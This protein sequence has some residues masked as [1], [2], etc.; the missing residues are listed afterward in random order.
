MF[1]FLVFAFD[2]NGRL[3][4]VPHPEECSSFYLCDHNLASLFTCQAGLAFD[5]NLLVC[6]YDH[7]VDCEGRQNTMSTTE[8]QGTYNFF[9][10]R[11]NTEY[12]ARLAEYR[13]LK[14]TTKIHFFGHFFINFE[15]IFATF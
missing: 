5:E 2:C 15:P 8:K 12:S 11:P 1:K 10:G 3:G 14:K 9:S 7:V 6:N 13:I 4:P